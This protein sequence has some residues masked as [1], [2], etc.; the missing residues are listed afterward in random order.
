MRAKDQT[1]GAVAVM[2]GTRLG[3]NSGTGS[4]TQRRISAAEQVDRLFAITSLPDIGD[5][6]AFMA[7]AISAF[8]AVPVEVGD[9]AVIE[10][11][12]RAD[13]PTLRIIREVLNEYLAREADRIR[14]QEARAARRLRLP[15]PPRSEEQQARVDAQVE[16]WRKRSSGMGLRKVDLPPSA[17]ARLDGIKSLGSAVGSIINDQ[18]S[19]AG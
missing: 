18:L 8:V 7:A 15:A 19:K 6:K 13:R 1:T 16:D 4:T 12:A 5:P 2:Q 11:A 14:L 3:S 9:A 10:I 17:G